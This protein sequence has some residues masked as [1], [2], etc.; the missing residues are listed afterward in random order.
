[1]E[2]RVGEEDEDAWEE[3][4]AVAHTMARAVRAAIQ[5]AL[6][7]RITAP[8]IRWCQS[9]LLARVCRMAQKDLPW[10]GES[11]SSTPATAFNVSGSPLPC[12]EGLAKQWMF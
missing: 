8:S 2:W 12:S 10:G 3:D 11:H 1:M 9:H 7:H 4:V 6:L 5:S